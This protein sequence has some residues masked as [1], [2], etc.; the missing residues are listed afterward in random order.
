MIALNSIKHPII[1]C[2]LTP[3]GYYESLLAINNST[4]YQKN[5]STTWFWVLSHLC[6]LTTRRLS[7]LPLQCQCF[8]R[9]EFPCR[10][11]PWWEN[12]VA[13]S[14][15]PARSDFRAA[16]ELARWPNFWPSLL[17]IPKQ[18]PSYG[19]SCRAKSGILQCW[20]K[21]GLM[22]SLLLKFNSVT[23]WP[24]MATESNRFVANTL[25]SRPAFVVAH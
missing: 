9:K 24:N 4:S 13:F 11:C 25:R 15:C 1:R 2:N 7:F 21:S 17:V 3:S 10:V 19:H 16:E 23:A 5:T 20:F 18:E 8:W 12:V 22:S 6:S 14:L